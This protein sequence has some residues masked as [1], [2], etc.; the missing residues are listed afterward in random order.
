MMKD[1]VFQQRSDRTWLVES[2][3]NGFDQGLYLDFLSYDDPLRF[4]GGKVEL[5]GAGYHFHSYL[6]RRREGGAVVVRLA[7]GHF[8]SDRK[9]VV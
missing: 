7:Q 8:R 1:R 2:F 4:V 9:S 6:I 5:I 3:Y